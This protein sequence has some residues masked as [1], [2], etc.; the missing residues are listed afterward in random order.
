MSS[1]KIVAGTTMQIV[2]NGAPKTVS[3]GLTVAALLS[4]IQVDPQKVAVE[5]NREIVRKKEWAETPVEA[6]A[7][8]EVVWFVGGGR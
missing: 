4:E 5:L 6:G 7:A 1:N 2:L 3:A 8:V